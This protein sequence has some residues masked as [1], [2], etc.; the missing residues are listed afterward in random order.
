VNAH[1]KQRQIEN[2]PNTTKSHVDRAN[3]LKNA[4][5]CEQLAAWLRELQE[6]R[7]APNII[8]CGECKHKRDLHYEEPGEEPYIKSICKNKYGLTEKYQVHDWDFC[9]RAERRTE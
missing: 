2:L 3:D 7:K 4:E 8:R 5:E 6:R 1:V 9:S